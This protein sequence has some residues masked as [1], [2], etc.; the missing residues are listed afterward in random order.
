M[1]YLSIAICFSLLLCLTNCATNENND[2]IAEENGLVSENQTSFSSEAAVN[3]TDHITESALMDTER[4]KDQ[5]QNAIDVEKQ[6]TKVNNNNEM[7]KLVDS[8]YNNTYIG[9]AFTSGSIYIEPFNVDRET[10]NDGSNLPK[11]PNDITFNSVESASEQAINAT[12]LGAF[13]TYVPH[14]EGDSHYFFQAFSEPDQIGFQYRTVTPPS[15]ILLGITIFGYR[16]ENL[17]F[18]QNGEPRPYSEQEYSDSIKLIDEDHSISMEDH[19]PLDYID[20]QDTILGAKIMCSFLI[21]GTDLR[22]QLSKYITHSTEYVS[23]VYVIDFYNGNQILKSY[24]KMNS[25]GP[26]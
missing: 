12:F 5:D 17:D 1:R 16:P 19:Q 4:P 9:E 8:I 13:N 22:V 24:Q 18:S 21:S 11:C 3:T 26:Y 6:G 23:E 7:M 2:S 15:N 14:I 20:K 25:D 10:W